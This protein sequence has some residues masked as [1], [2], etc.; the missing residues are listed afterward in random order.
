MAEASPIKLA[1]A[2]TTDDRTGLA[3]QFS[4]WGGVAGVC[5]QLLSEQDKSGC[6]DV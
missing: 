6:Q 1:M 4:C 3:R 5:M 2:T